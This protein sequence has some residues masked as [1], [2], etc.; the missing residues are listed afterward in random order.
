MYIYIYIYIYI[1]LVTIETYN[2]KRSKIKKIITQILFL[3]HLIKFIWII[4]F[5]FQV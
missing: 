1:K 3:G 5:T 4:V 2:R